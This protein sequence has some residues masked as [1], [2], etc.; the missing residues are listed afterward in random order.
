MQEIIP[1]AVQGSLWMGGGIGPASLVQQASHST[2]LFASCS[3]TPLPFVILA[4]LGEPIHCTPL[5]QSGGFCSK[6]PRRRAGAT[7]GRQNAAL[8]DS[9][10][11][12][13]S[14]LASIFFFCGRGMS[15]ASRDNGPPAGHGDVPWRFSAKQ[16]INGRLLSRS[17]PSDKPAE[18]TIPVHSA[19]S[20]SFRAWQL[21]SPSRFACFGLRPSPDN[22]FAN[23]ARP[24]DGWSRD[25]RPA[26][27]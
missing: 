2:L 27:G 13:S 8:A 6:H 15:L 3:A 19:L 17:G 11:V 25:Q 10:A 12:L 18:S 14:V 7:G 23:A 5:R 24:L 1:F 22:P 20:G 4:V 26:M 9:A 21:A 16:I